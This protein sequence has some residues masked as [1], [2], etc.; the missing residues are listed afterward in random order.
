M[1]FIAFYIPFLKNPLKF[2]GIIY[3][4]LDSSERLLRQV[5]FVIV[6]QILFFMSVTYFLGTL[7][8][9]NKTPG[10]ISTSYLIFFYLSRSLNYTIDLDIYIS[11]L[12][13]RPNKTLF[14]LY[15]YDHPDFETT[16]INMGTSLERAIIGPLFLIVTSLVCILISYIF[17]YKREK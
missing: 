16:L 9:S 12:S 13:P 2:T 14:Y 11:Y 6:P 15:Y 4:L 7:T 8:K 17:T 5:L 3:F 10:I 1:T